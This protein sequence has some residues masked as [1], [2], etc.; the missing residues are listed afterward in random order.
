MQAETQLTWPVQEFL[1]HSLPPAQLPPVHTQ[2]QAW[3]GA[4]AET[5]AVPPLGV[6]V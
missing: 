6:L 5:R 3:T 4:G 2:A 1:A